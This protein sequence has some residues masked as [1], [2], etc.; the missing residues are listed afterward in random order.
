MKPAAMPASQPGRVSSHGAAPTEVSATPSKVSPGQTV[1]CSEARLA[2]ATAPSICVHDM[3]RLSSVDATPSSMPSSRS[4][5]ASSSGPHVSSSGS[6]IVAQFTSHSTRPLAHLE[7]GLFIA[8]KQQT[9]LIRATFSSNV[10]RSHVCVSDTEGMDSAFCAETPTVHA[11]HAKAMAGA[12]IRH[13]GAPLSAPPQVA[14]ARRCRK[15]VWIV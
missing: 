12:N 8:P 5:I 6:S 11:A 1:A 10:T 14:I 15:G 3:Y 9:L 4:K 13:A 7:A 2:S